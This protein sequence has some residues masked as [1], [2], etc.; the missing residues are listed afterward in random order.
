MG[1]SADITRAVKSLALD[2]GFSAVSVTGAGRAAGAERFGEWLAAGRHAGMAHMERRA[3]ERFDPA[4]HLDGAASVICLAVGYAPDEAPPSPPDAP[5]MPFVAQFA[6]G[7]DY[8]RA[9][10]RR[11]RRLMEAVARIEPSFRGTA[12][13]DSAPLAE[14]SLAAGAG[15]GWIG[16]NGCLIVPRLGSYVVLA[17]IV[18]NLPLRPDEPMR[19]A[20]SNCRRCVDACPTGALGGDGIVD[21]RKCLS[22]LTVEHRGEIPAEARGLMGRRV[23]GCDTCQAVCPYNADVPPGDAELTGEPPRPGDAPRLH[24]TPLGEVL[25]WSEAD[26]DAATRGSTVR[27]AKYPSLLRNAAIAAGCSGDARLAGPL[28]A[29]AERSP[30]LAPVAREAMKRLGASG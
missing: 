3:G 27:R 11:C 5:T 6:R 14:R 9:M 7:R 4:A 25:A 26:W 17:E 16:R 12:F 21:C 24:H 15:L 28:K 18:C 23:F 19:S 22:Y 30:E 13:T 29:L 2:C 8:H 20:C 10:R 1:A